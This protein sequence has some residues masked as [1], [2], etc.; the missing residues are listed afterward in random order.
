MNRLDE[1]IHSDVRRALT[2]LRAR[3]SANLEAFNDAVPYASWLR[4]SEIESFTADLTRATERAPQRRRLVFL[5]KITPVHSWITRMKS[6]A[7]ML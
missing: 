7:R 2:E 3:T 1:A 5:D 4:R 6:T